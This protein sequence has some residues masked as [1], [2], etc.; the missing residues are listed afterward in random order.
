M[1]YSMRLELAGV[2]SVN[3]FPL[4]PLVMFFLMNAGPSFFLECVSFSP[5][6]SSFTFDV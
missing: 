6:Y 3:G 1:G 4:V 2:C 5:L